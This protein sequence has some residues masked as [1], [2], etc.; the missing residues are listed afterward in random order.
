[1]DKLA[2]GKDVPKEATDL[3]FSIEKNIK[4]I[5]EAKNKDISQI[6]A[7]LLDRPRHKEKI[8]KL[9]KFKC[10]LKINI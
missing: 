7:C 8:D 1:M 2:V 6:T 10:K 5:A 4:N 3:D 9:K